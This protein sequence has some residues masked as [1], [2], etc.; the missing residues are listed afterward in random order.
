MNCL[1]RMLLQWKSMHIVAY[2]YRY[3][4]DCEILCYKIIFFLSYIWSSTLLLLIRPLSLTKL[5]ISPFYQ[6]EYLNLKRMFNLQIFLKLSIHLI[7]TQ[8][9]IKMTELQF[10]CS[11]PRE[12]ERKKNT[13]QLQPWTVLTGWTQFNERKDW[14]LGT[15]TPSYQK[16]FWTIWL[17]NGWTNE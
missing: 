9:L 13:W 8:I 17:K 4:G 14:S 15:G 7:T 11:Y 10:T 1:S 16:L 2:Y 6:F 5:F 3:S 12:R